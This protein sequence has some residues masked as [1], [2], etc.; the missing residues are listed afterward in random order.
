M[1]VWNGA[2]HLSEAIESILQQSFSDFE[3]IV[4][5]D[6]STDGT[7][8]ILDAYR[9]SRLKIH[10]LQHGGIVAALNHGVA[11]SRAP[12]IARQDAD[13]I[14][15]PGRLEAQRKA[16][17]TNQELTLCYTGVELFGPGAAGLEPVRIPRTT[18]LTALRLCFHCPI[19]HSSV[20][21]RKEAFVASGGYLYRDRHVEDFAAW[22]RL[23]EHGPF[24]GLREPLVKFRVH[25]Q[26]V[27]QRN[28]QEQLDQTRRIATLHCARF[29]RLDD[30]HAERAFGALTNPTA[31]NHWQE[32]C[33]FL[34]RVAPRL[35]WQSFEMWL[36][37][38]ARTFRR[39]RPEF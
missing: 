20:M 22:G 4:V 8:E 16:V 14:S 28:L 39:F 3:L 21:F 38:A 32:W 19:V 17:N 1:P 37:L 7:P 15:L 35:R 5:D 33:W 10:R 26:S 29:L 31:P 2:D 23:L 12:W 18:A 24:I 11:Q 27:S 9:D 25:S 30:R 34:S 13:D 6:G 36:W